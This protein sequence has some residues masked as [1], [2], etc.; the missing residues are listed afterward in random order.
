MSD[1]LQST[2]EISI[3]EFFEKYV[4]GKIVTFYKVEIYDNYSKENWIL[5]KRYS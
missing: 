1:Y 4:D 5:E 3:S 2:I